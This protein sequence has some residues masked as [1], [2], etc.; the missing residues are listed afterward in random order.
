MLGQLHKWRR[1]VDPYPIDGLKALLRQGLERSDGAARNWFGL[2][3]ACILLRERAGDAELSTVTGRLARGRD[4]RVLIAPGD[5]A[6]FDDFGRLAALR[7][8]QASG[9]GAAAPIPR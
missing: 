1:W 3:L 2:T 4:S 9:P 8:A 6:L 5:E 7:G